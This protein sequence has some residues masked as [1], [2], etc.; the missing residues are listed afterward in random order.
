VLIGK[1][2]YILY[3]PKHTTKWQIVFWINSILLLYLTLMPAV[4]HSVN[5]RDIDKVFH[6]IGFGSFAF[7]CVLAF[8]RLNTLWA[9]FIS[10]LLGMSVE[11]VQSFLPHR[12]F[13]FADMIADFAGIIT[14]VIFLWIGKGI[15]REWRV[16][17]C[18]EKNNTTGPQAESRNP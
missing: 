17:S 8:S 6:F 13:S 4:H 9:I 1:F 18:Q 3:Q 5:Y 15:G 2:F 11:I 10:C 7:F 16:A 14:A 12:A